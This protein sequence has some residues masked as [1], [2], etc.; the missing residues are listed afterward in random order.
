MLKSI[1]RRLSPSIRA[2]NWRFV[3]SSV[4]SIRREGWIPRLVISD[5]FRNHVAWTSR[6]LVAVGVSASLVEFGSKVEAFTVAI[7]LVILQ[8][9]FE[10]VVYQ[11]A[12]FYVQ[13][14]PDFRYYV[15]AWKGMGFAFPVE[16]RPDQLNVVGPE[17][18]SEE[19]S[20]S[21]FGL[22]RQWNYGEN[23]DTNNNVCLSFILE[24]AYKYSVYLYPNPK[25]QSAKEFFD[26]ADALHRSKNRKGEHHSFLVQFTMLRT[27]RR[28]KT[29]QLDTFIDMQSKSRPFWLKPFIRKDGQPQMVYEI[30]PILKHH[31]TVRK[32]QDLRAGDYE[33]E[34]N[35]QY[36]RPRG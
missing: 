19:Y 29:S 22:F 17:F 27:F 16:Q 14:F 25:R 24:D 11:F 5:K 36:N 12:S 8:F 35:W 2:G 18:S 15:Q 1:F 20:N 30:E 21:I 9:F 34:L 32:R 3:L 31:V 10:R 26:M 28:E 4:I 33:F 6:I 7:V 23:D 13:P